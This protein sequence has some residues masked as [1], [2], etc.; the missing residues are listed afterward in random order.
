MQ[1]AQTIQTFALE[2]YGPAESENGKAPGALLGEKEKNESPHPRLISIVI[3]DLTMNSPTDFP[4]MI[5][6]INLDSEV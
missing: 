6:A 2:S 3:D 1:S 5:D 4:P